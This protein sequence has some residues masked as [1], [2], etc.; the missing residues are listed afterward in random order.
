M[1][2]KRIYVIA[3]LV[4]VIFLTVTFFCGCKGSSQSGGGESSKK[5]KITDLA[6]R[7][8][9]V[10]VPAKRLVA[11]GPGALRLLCYVGC[12]EK[13]VGI[14][15]ME[16]QWSTG[17][18]Y[19]IA[20][21][22]LLDLPVIGQGGPD[23]T[24]DAE[25]LV[26]VKPDVIFV[27]YLV[28][29]GKAD[30]LQSKTGI[31]V[32]VLSYGKLGTFD[33]EVVCESV[34][35]IGE[36]TGNSQRAN[37]VVA[38]MKDCERDLGR[39][40]AKI[41]QKDKPS[42]YV[43]GLGM[44]GTHGIES[45]QGQFPPLVAIGARN[46]VDETGS[47]GSVMIDKEK[48]LQWDPDIIFIDEAGLQK[49]REDYKT[50]PGFYNTLSAVKKGKVFGFLPY[51]YYTTNIDTAIADAYFMGTVVFPELFKDIDPKKKADEIYEFLLGKPLYDRMEKDFGGFMEI[52]F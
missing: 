32:I 30:E 20:H 34:S 9:E 26:S 42:V 51:N 45:S 5:R 46:L 43:G 41:S 7:Q 12:A 40:T 15:N 13:V 3:T 6:G 33:N 52:K 4:S 16:K 2:G 19:I 49:V 35:I 37:K 48:I 38:F 25:K 23:S 21:P 17:R 31:P 36:I 24:P 14:E 39:R 10:A 47:K 1:S 11:I 28:D 44:K 27:A 18:P 8:V 50:N 29:A 22:E